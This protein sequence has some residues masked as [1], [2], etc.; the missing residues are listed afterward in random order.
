MFLKLRYI[1]GEIFISTCLGSAKLLI[2]AQGHALVL[3]SLKKQFLI[4]WFMISIMLQ[5]VCQVREVR[6]NS[7][8]SLVHRQVRKKSGNLG[9]KSEGSQGFFLRAANC[10]KSIKISINFNNF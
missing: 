3:I 4:G 6:E 7:E 2:I 8:N 10:R 9:K 5:G 1:P